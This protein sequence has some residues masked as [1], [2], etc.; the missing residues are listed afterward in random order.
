MTSDSRHPEIR[1]VALIGGGAISRHH[2]A[3]WKRL[4]NAAQV[5]AVCDPDLVRARAFADEFG[6][7]SVYADAQTLFAN[8]S[9]DLLDIA[10]PR[11]THVFWVDAGAE[12][13]L[14]ILCQKPLAPS[15]AEAEALARQTAGRARLMVHEN[16]RFRP[17]YRQLKR[18]L[19]SGVVGDIVTGSMAM[20]SSGLVADPAGRR[21]TFER[22]P[23]MRHERRLLIGETLIHHLD[24]LR[25]LAGPLRVVAARARRAIPEVDG[26]TA[27]I[28]LLENSAGIPVVITA[29][30]AAPG[31]PARTQ[32]RLTLVGGNG[33]AVLD[34]TH[35]QF[36]GPDPRQESYDPDEGYQSS[37]NEAISHFIECLRSGEDFETDPIDNLQTLRLVEDAY[38]MSGYCL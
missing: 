17:W 24:V 36:L 21:P 8:E 35:L 13:G 32:D 33:T 18:W 15:F 20:F 23:S 22:Q 2:L 5:V 12:R 7:P 37:F 26:E 38:R 28:I 4:G 10:S 31:L 25:W 19:D 16:W 14:D 9:L 34:G 3:A 27:A 6:I 1:R 29:T 30:T 11:T